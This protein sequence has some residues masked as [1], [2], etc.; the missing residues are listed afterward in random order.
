MSLEDCVVVLR[1][2]CVLFTLSTGEVVYLKQ[3]SR[4]WFHGC[5]GLSFPSKASTAVLSFPVL[6]GGT[7]ASPGQSEGI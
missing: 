6:L 7:V 5:S 4:H 1:V 2:L 3:W